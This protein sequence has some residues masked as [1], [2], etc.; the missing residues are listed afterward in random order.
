MK[1]A[2]QFIVSLILGILLGIVGLII[3]AMIGGNF[4]F[5]E[6]GGNL[7]YEAGGAFFGILGISLGN[8]LGAI[9]IKELSKE[10][11]NYLI[12]L[13]TAVITAVIGLL[14]F[15]YYMS[16]FVGLTILFLPT[17]VLTLVTNKNLS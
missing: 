10:K 5:P 4:S 9:I 1:I 11:I 15:D 17:L 14:S 16:S 6:F 2:L 13:C 7:G 12:T 8:L 3:G